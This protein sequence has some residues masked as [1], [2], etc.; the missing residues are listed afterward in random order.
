MIR[1]MRETMTTLGMITEERRGKSWNGQCMKE[2]KENS[3]L[4]KL[5]KK[6]SKEKS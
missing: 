6:V 5:L 2:C 4:I 1:W 3:S